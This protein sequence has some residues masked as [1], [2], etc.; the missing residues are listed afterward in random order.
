MDHLQEMRYLEEEVKKVLAEVQKNLTRISQG[1]APAN[2]ADKVTERLDYAKGRIRAMEMQQREVEDRQEARRY[3]PIIKD[4]QDELR[5]LDQQLQWTTGGKRKTEEEQKHGDIAR[6]ENAAIDYGREMQNR[7]HDLADKGIEILAETEEKA[8][9]TA[10][11]VHQQTEQMKKIDTNLSEIDNELDRATK[12]M[13]RMG[14]RVMTDKYIMCL[15]IL[16][17]IAIIAVIVLAIEKNQISTS[18]NTSF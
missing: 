13:K 9:A 18:S 2:E 14:R 5:D 8:Q 17:F 3:N 11:Q 15:V 10:Q 1:S 4:L 16:V 6:D 7:Q 12:I